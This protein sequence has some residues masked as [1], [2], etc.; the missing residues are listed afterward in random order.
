MRH[1]GITCWMLVM[2]L[3]LKA[4][5]ISSFPAT[6]NFDAFTLC[7][8]N[9]GASCTLSAGWVNATNDDLDWATY[10]GAT[11]TGNTGPSGD[12]SAGGTGKYLYVESSN[13]CSPLKTASL[14][15]PPLNLTGLTNF[16][17]DFWYHLYGNNMGSIYV[18]VS[19]D[20]GASFIQMVVPQITANLNQW[21]LKT[22]DLSSFV[23]DTIILRI[24][25]V[26]GNGSLSDIAID[27]FTFYTLSSNDAGVFSIDS[28]SNPVV[29]GLQNVIVRIKNFGLSQLTSSTINWS[30]NGVSQ[31]PYAW[32]G[33]LT[34]SQVSSPVIIGAYNFMAGNT[35]LRVWTSDPNG[36][37]DANPAN[38]TL[39]LQ[40]CPALNGTFSVGGPSADFSSLTAAVNALAICGIAG[41]VTLDLTPGAGPFIEQ[42]TLPAV[43][44]ASATNTI[45]LKGNGETLSF[46]PTASDRHLIKLDGGKHWIIDNLHIV[47]TSPDYGWGIFIINQ[48]DSNTIKNCTIDLSAV[49]STVIDNSCGVVA[50]ASTVSVSVAG[51]NTNHLVLENNNIIGGFSGVRLSGA[52]FT[53][54]ANNRI[55][56]NTI[57]DFYSYGIYLLDNDNTLVSANDIRRDTRTNGGTF[58]GIYL[59]A[60][61]QRTLIE[62]NRIHNTHDAISAASGSTIGIFTSA[63]APTGLENRI[64]NNLIYNFNSNGTIYGLFN[65]GADGTYYYHN[66]ISLD[67]LPSTGATTRGFFQNTL[68][69]NIQFV[70]NVVTVLRG[71]GGNKHCV[72]LGN[73]GSSIIIDYNVYYTDTN[74]NHVGYWGA[75]FTT[76]SDWQ[77]ANGGAYDAHSIFANPLYV[78]SSLGDF[79]PANNLIN[80]AG[81]NVSVATDI[82]GNV[83]NSVTPDPGAYEFDPVFVDASITWFSPVPPV[84]GGSHLITVNIANSNFSQSAITEINLTYSDNTVFITENFSGLNIAPG[85]NQNLSF[86]TPYSLTA[87]VVMKAYIN[88]V[89]TVMDAVRTNDTIY[90]NLCPSLS[91]A[92]TIDKTLPASATNFI[93]FTKAVEALSFCGIAGPVAISVLNGP[94][95]EQ[96]E[97][98]AIPGVSAAD[99]VVIHGNNTTINYTPN[100]TSRHILKLNGASYI[101]I[102][103]LRL[104]VIDSTYGWAVHLMNG[105][106]HITLDSCSIDLSLIKNTNL[107]DFAGIVATNS[108]T[109][110][111]GT[112]NTAH[113]VTIKNCTIINGGYGIRFNGDPS[114]KI[115]GN[116]FLN[117]TIRDFYSYGIFLSYADS[118]IISNNRISRPNRLT[119]GPFYGIALATACERTV[120]S[121]N[122]IFNP[123]G[124]MPGSTLPAY[125]V[126]LD[127]SDATAGREN[128][129]YNNLIYQMTSNGLISALY[130]SGSDYAVYYHNTIVIDDSASASTDAA[131]CFFQITPAAGVDVKNN[132]FYLRRG[133]T[134][135][136]YCLQFN[137]ASSNITSDYN[138]LFTAGG[139]NVFTGRYDT[140]DYVSLNDWKTANSGAFDQHSM[141]ADPQFVNAAAGD[142]TPTSILVNNAGTAVGVLSDIL[143]QPR[144]A[145][146]PD[147]G[148]YEFT[149]TALDAAISWVAPVSPVSGAQSVIV[150]ITN[151]QNQI[152]NKLT[153]SYSDDLNTVKETFTGLN[154]NGGTSQDI[155]FTTPVILSGATYLYAFIDSVNGTQDANRL[156]DTT[157]RQFLCTTLSGNYT[158]NR[159][160]PPSATNFQSFSDVARAL[161]VCGITAPVVFDVVAGSGPYNEQVEFMSVPGAS[162]VNTI[163]INGNGNT[164]S[165]AP[166]SGKRYLIKL[167]GTRHITLHDLQMVATGNTY[168]YGL[169][170]T[171]RADS[172]RIQGCTIDL[173]AVSSTVQANSTGIAFSASDLSTSASGNN[174]NYNYIVGN[175]ITGGYHGIRINGS[176]A[177]TARQN[178]IQGNVIRDFYAYGV[179]ISDA[180]GTVITDNDISR[181]NRADVTTFYGVYL[182]SCIGSNVERNRI[183]NT[184]DN[185]LSLS[186]A[187]YPIYLQSCAAYPGKENRVVNNIIYNINSNGTVYAIYNSASSGSQFYHNS[188]S[189]DH[190]ASTAIG[191]TRGFYKASTGSDVDFR[192]NIISI[193][194]GG[195][196]TK[197]CVYV[198]NPSANLIID[199]NI[200]FTDTTQ[201]QN[202][203]GLY[204]G[205]NYKGFPA[206][207][208]GSTFDA[209]SLF[210][211]PQFANPAGGNL[212]PISLSIDNKGT[213][214]GV[215][216]DILQ[217][218]RDTITPDVGAYE[219]TPVAIDA[220]VVALVEPQNKNCGSTAMDIKVVIANFGVDTISGVPVTVILSGAASGTFTASSSRP[221]VN[222]Q[223]DTLLVGTFNL[224]T[225]GATQFTIFTSAP[226]DGNS[227]NDTL[228]QIVDITPQATQPVLLPYA[229]SICKSATTT[230]EVLADSMLSYSWY[231][232]PQG[233]NRIHVGTS[234]TTPMLDS[235]VTY[236]VEASIEIAYRLG[237]ADTAIG[238][239]GYLPGGAQGLVFE[240]YQEFTLDSVA[241]YVQDTGTV[242]VELS[243]V[244]NLNVLDVVGV[245]VSAPQTKVF[246]PV[247]FTIAPGIYRIDANGSTVSGL[248]RNDMGA[249]YPYTVAGVASITGSTNPLGPNHYYYFYDWKITVAGC[250]AVRTAAPVFVDT[251]SGQVSSSFVTAAGGSGLDIAFTADSFRSTDTYAWDFGDGS[252]ATGPATVHV[253]GA[254]G[255]YQACLTVSNLCASETTCSNLTV[256][257]PLQAAVGFS[258]N[259]LSAHYAYAG[260]GTPVGFL[261]DF[262]DGVTS[263]DSTPVHTYASAGTFT[264]TLIVEN[265]CGKRDTTQQ[266]ITICEPL[267]ADFSFTQV[268]PNGLTFNFSDSSSGNIISYLWNFGDGSSNTNPSTAHAYQ[269]HGNYTV[270]LIV[271]D[272]CGN[273]DTVNYLLT[274]CAPP[275]ADFTA[276]VQGDQKTVNI[277]NSS[278]GAD[279]TFSWNF[280]DGATSVLPAPSHSYAATGSYTIVLEVTDACG[281]T[282]KDSVTVLIVVTGV[283]VPGPLYGVSGSPNPVVNGEALMLHYSLS[284]SSE[285]SIDIY[286]VDGKRVYQNFAV[287]SSGKHRQMIYLSDLTEGFYLLK[288][289]AGKQVIPIKLI[290]M[291]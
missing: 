193:T 125:G 270:V 263:S 192:N 261:W 160:A 119:G 207:Q 171:G 282:D 239:G 251:I 249:T 244:S 113:H 265:L 27:D 32:S 156:N 94:Y 45:T 286:T 108:N 103:N 148:A 138:V 150:R 58:Y 210:G 177:D 62:K 102:R 197:H 11:P 180:E 226:G 37:A 166:T 186:G 130:N 250:P 8:S 105:A 85:N 133:G 72:Y 25:G 246:I 63:D 44:G 254:D 144:N 247:G 48:A 96:I 50:S 273:A 88:S 24:R 23:G 3:G 187:S 224:L 10:S 243:D 124:S 129:I 83:R 38:D 161:S 67:H 288:L 90:Q 290:V 182:T 81:T 170:F 78:N 97:I 269:A 47:G 206:W 219:F 257:A 5:V 112:G 61:C 176:A 74:V 31:T 100:G 92:Y 64:V 19:V 141:H 255:T 15:S 98:P 280:G 12:H 162:A 184:H 220:T 142:F 155:S 230:I 189:L 114:G 175:T 158:I 190:A 222:G 154:I 289:S 215:M 203:I 66:T 73:A 264:V 95:V 200:Y 284:Q 217:N 283:E 275:N 241:V 59:D 139:N 33:A 191:P 253:Y 157:A 195:S 196:G 71:G 259:G 28:P 178:V 172:N 202:N 277:A 21:Q 111:G 123:T 49:T 107:N 199:Y 204:N 128:K 223:T 271:T 232:Q 169:L 268:V 115:T 56:G 188:I 9:C 229:D 121:G 266:Q 285:V 164:L 86:S 117:N 54:S 159:N 82:L 211:N 4:Q 258:A 183:H 46:S 194:R 91:G 201:G 101:T 2:V 165:F 236:Y 240:A 260:T 291:K 80:N 89:N 109:S 218:A 132:I 227:Q 42:L 214:V 235:S 41:P 76:L 52:Q 279:L 84:S 147:P 135:N 26:T 225:G 120:I 43:S 237:P 14:L 55:I 87:A 198:T 174:G 262:G 127:E 149:P 17:V 167:N 163:T 22:I 51:N 213:P 168:G 34:S 104:S 179:F 53:K 18:D 216:E 212:L 29:A 248:Y 118:S 30:V 20:N 153:L 69:S 93:S 231:D 137:S 77:T 7:S 233:G 221:I 65:S 110:I 99:T 136:K 16:Y 75:D 60:R 140:T 245:H 134:G 256:C 122:R 40:F 70:N 208:A 13:P 173:S 36:A 228:Q 146:T 185:A 68:A 281:Q 267:R 39:T 205:V 238:T 274:T 1:L 131:S 6:Q 126:Y 278:S 242:Y 272:N 181:A 116:K 106:S 252:T 151:T 287:M 143:Q 57:R 209:N 276:T 145:T 35:T 79:T 234:F 152:I